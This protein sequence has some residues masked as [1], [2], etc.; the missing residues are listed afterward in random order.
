MRK[1]RRL[2]RGQRIKRAHE[3]KPTEKVQRCPRRILPIEH[4]RYYKRRRRHRA[5]R[6]VAAARRVRLF[7]LV[8]EPV[9]EHRMRVAIRCP[10]RRSLPHLFLV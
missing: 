10:N 1:H 4:F 5:I 2:R 9:R 6:P 7:A 8:P 3:D